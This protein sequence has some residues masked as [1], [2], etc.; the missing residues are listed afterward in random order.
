MPLKQFPRESCGKNPNLNST[1]LP[2]TF[3]F[4]R[5]IESAAGKA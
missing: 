5:P 4:C 3:S 2:K 1:E